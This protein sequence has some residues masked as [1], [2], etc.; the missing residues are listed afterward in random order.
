M[1]EGITNMSNNIAKA[2]VWISIG[3]TISIGLITTKDSSC[4][5]ALIIV[6]MV[7]GD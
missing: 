2:C 4:L 1:E 6:A 5:I 7:I 3:I